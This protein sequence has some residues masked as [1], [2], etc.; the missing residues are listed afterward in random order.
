[1]CVASAVFAQG[2]KLRLPTT[3]FL[4]FLGPPSGGPSS[5]WRLNSELIAE[6]FSV[7]GSIVDPLSRIGHHIGHL[8]QPGGRGVQRHDAID[9]F[10]PAN[11]ESEI[12]VVV[13]MV[14]INDEFDVPDRFPA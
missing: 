3:D 13:V 4:V 2:Q 6:R 1:M 7:V 14:V 11:L 8:Q 5:L 10:E 9:A 12:V